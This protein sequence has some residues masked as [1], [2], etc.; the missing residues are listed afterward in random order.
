[1]KCTVISILI[2]ATT[3]AVGAVPPTISY[4]GRVQVS[5]TNFSGTG[6]FKFALVS[7]GTNLN[8]QAT[9]TATVTSG[10]V[11]SISVTD[12]GFG[13]TAPP[14]VTITGATGSG[15]TATANVSGGA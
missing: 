12:G 15:A 4:Q 10:F 8:R 2:L 7:K 11:T 13:Y 14:A 9:A 3:L 5:G 6:L 1:M